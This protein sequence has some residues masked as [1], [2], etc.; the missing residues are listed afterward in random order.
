MLVYGIGKYIQCHFYVSGDLWSFFVMRD[1]KG[2]RSILYD[3]EW[4]MDESSAALFWL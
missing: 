1:M 4:I 3:V 2:Y